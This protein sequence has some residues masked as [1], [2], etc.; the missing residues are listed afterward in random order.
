ML[1][2]PIDMQIF[3]K[4]KYPGTAWGGVQQDSE[5]GEMKVWMAKGM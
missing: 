5:A 1:N 2:D 3:F 4:V